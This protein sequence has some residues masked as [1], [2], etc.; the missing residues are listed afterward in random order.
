MKRK[1]LLLALALLAALLPA[2]ARAADG[3]I[4]PRG[5][6]VRGRNLDIVVDRGR[7]HDGVS[8][9]VEGQSLRVSGSGLFSATGNEI[10]TTIIVNTSESMPEAA[11]GKL[12]EFLGLLAGRSG[13]TERV[14]LIGVG[15]GAVTVWQDFTDNSLHLSSA[16]DRML[17][18]GFSGEP[19]S[20]ADAI[21]GELPE[22]GESGELVY[23]RLIVLTDALHHELGGATPEELYERRWRSPVAVFVGEVTAEPTHAGLP[24]LAAIASV[25]W[26][27]VPGWAP[28]VVMPGNALS[29]IEH[30]DSRNAYWVRAA[31]PGRLLDGSDRTILVRFDDEEFVFQTY[32]PEHAGGIAA[33]DLPVIGAIAGA[34]SAGGFPWPWVL[35]AA[36][37]AGAL[38]FIAAKARPRFALPRAA[39][40]GAAEKAPKQGDSA[41]MQYAIADYNCANIKLKNATTGVS[42]GYFPAD[43]ALTVGCDRACDVRLAGK[44]GPRC[45][46]RRDG[47]GLV[48]GNPGRAGIVKV[49]GQ[50]LDG[51]RELK[52]GD[53]IACGKTVLLVEDI[54][55]P[56]AAKKEAPK[57]ARIYDV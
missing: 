48:I 54:F 37:G 35:A 50:L 43:G 3:L 22:R 14:R 10:R 5:V 27:F 11:A 53:E 29:D 36:A 55:V 39:K 9:S 8:V 49:G 47:D 30:V 19:L 12:A 51:P 21:L 32:F 7:R 24:E 31:V 56:N 33:A 17:Y 52:A 23:E 41:E 2:L 42:L 34:I 1:R 6:T 44:G 57:T 38:A 25:R 15:G 46:I 45:E 18:G 16:V 4:L 13:P 28:Y 26:N 20:I 40:K